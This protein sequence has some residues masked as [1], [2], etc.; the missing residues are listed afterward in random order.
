MIDPDTLIANDSEKL[1][2]ISNFELDGGQTLAQARID[3]VTLGT[4]QLDSNGHIN[5]AILLIRGNRKQLAYVFG[6]MVEQPDV[7]PWT[8][9]RSQQHVYHYFR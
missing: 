2:L 6:E 7:W 8:T 4:P 3:Y 9:A 1:H 5:N